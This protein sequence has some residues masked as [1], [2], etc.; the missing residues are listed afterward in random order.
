MANTLSHDK[1]NSSLQESSCAIHR[2]DSDSQIHRMQL[3]VITRDIKG[4]SG[5]HVKKTK[6]TDAACRLKYSNSNEHVSNK[7]G[8]S[9]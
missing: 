1:T 3:Y 6:Q 4:S 2:D 5:F 9:D 7:C 8:S